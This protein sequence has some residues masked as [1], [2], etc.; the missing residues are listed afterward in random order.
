MKALCT[1]GLFVS[2]AWFVPAAQAVTEYRVI[3]LPESIPGS[4]V[5][6]VDLNENGQVL[7]WGVGE[8]LAWHGFIYENEQLTDFGVPEGMVAFYGLALNNTGHVAGYALDAQSANHLFLWHQGFGFQPLSGG[9]LDDPDV[10]S[11]SVVDLNDSL[12]V[13]GSYWVQQAQQTA[14]RGFIWRNGQAEDLGDLELGG[15]SIAFIPTA[16]NDLGQIVGGAGLPDGTDT[17]VLWQN[18]VLTNLGTMSGFSAR[19]RG[20]SDAGSIVG[21]FYQLNPPPNAWSTQA[22]LYQNGSPIDL[23]PGGAEAYDFSTAASVN[24]L[25]EVVGYRNVTNVGYEAFLWR[26]GVLHDLQTLAEVPPGLLLRLAMRINDRGDILGEARDLSAGFDRSVLLSRGGILRPSFGQ[27]IL[28]GR[29]D[30]IRWNLPAEM[31][32]L[33]IELNTHARSEPDRY[34]PVGTAQAQAGQFGWT[35]VPD[36][37]S[38]QCRIRVYSP[39]FPDTVYSAL[40]RMKP[41]MLTRLDDQG[42]YVPWKM[43]RDNWS[44]GNNRAMWWPETWWAG[45]PD[46]DYEDGVDPIAGRPYPDFP[47]PS[48]AAFAGAPDSLF[49]DWPLFVRTF[50]EAQCYEN[51]AEGIYNPTALWNWFC[52]REAWLG[53]CAGMAFSALMNF[54]DPEEMRNR[55]PALEAYETL[56]DDQPAA[57]DLRLIVN[58]LQCVQEGADQLA[59]ARE[60]KGTMTPRDVVR[61]LEEEFA[62]DEPAFLGPLGLYNLEEGGGHAVV[63]FQILTDH[64]GAD[65]TWFI[66]TYDPNK[67][68]DEGF[69]R[70]IQR[71]GE[72]DARWNATINDRIWSGTGT[73]LTVDGPADLDYGESVQL[74][75]AFTG[76]GGDSPAARNER[77]AAS[78]DFTVFTSARGSMALTASNRPGTAGY[79]DG[80]PVDDLPGVTP[81]YRQTGVIGP[82]S[83]YLI[84]GDHT[85]AT[86]TFAMGDGA[87]AERVLGVFREDGSV[88]YLRAPGDSAATDRVSFGGGGM[89]IGVAAAGTPGAPKSIALTTIAQDYD[90]KKVWMVSEIELAEGDSIRVDRV[91]WTE[92]VRILNAGPSPRTCTLGL[93]RA[94]ASSDPQFLATGIGL[95]AGASLR[96]VADW[97]N[98]ADAPVSIQVDLGNDGSVDEIIEVENEL[99]EASADAPDEPQVA[100]FEFRTHPLAGGTGGIHIQGTIPVDCH[101][102]VRAYD[103]MGRNLGTIFDGRHGAGELSLSW[104][105]GSG[106]RP[107]SGICFVRLEAMDSDGRVLYRGARKALIVR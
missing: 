26:E 37:V 53:S 38:T 98:L 91:A 65:S 21:D 32:L 23:D 19:A 8:D 27:L 88:C 107:A 82:P 11:V 61:I 73:G 59:M 72:P 84:S 90:H 17:V 28:S 25:D 45:N 94:S 106:A 9:L 92:D 95:P 1:I 70:V 55:F 63:P 34:V 15:P 51:V 36:S 18:H 42:D 46:F 52:R 67:R 86:H 66:W 75:P 7:C 31:G 101:V 4:P 39:G 100:D 3:P 50:G 29:A 41:L 105:R 102:K 104:A 77:Y 16:I 83:S 64:S 62:R 44:Q 10:F 68:D 33:Q 35:I 93:E 14:Q 20:I 13:V 57:D 89:E 6:A 40:F 49:A 74:L 81:L 12:Q 80:Q 69:V 24:G 103:V 60:R 22:F 76:G 30:S 58:Q 79:V 48:S 85:F 71:P 5:R 96:I 47:Y 97:S 2:M 78:E 99:E 54:L 43:T 56:P 87:D